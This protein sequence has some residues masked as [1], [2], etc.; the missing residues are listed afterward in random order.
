[1]TRVRFPPS[2]STVVL[3]A[4]ALGIAGCTVLAP[5]PDRTRFYLLAALAETPTTVRA[6]S[7]APVGLGPVRLPDYLGRL[8][9]AARTGHTEIRYASDDR[10]AEPLEQGM[11][12]VLAEN[13]TALLGGRTV[14]ALPNVLRR[15]V[16]F[17][18]PVEVLRFEPDA[19]GAVVLI[20]RW[21]VRDNAAAT[22]LAESHE[23]R[24]REPRIASDGDSG[25]SAMSRAALRLAEEIA[26]QIRVHE[27]L[28]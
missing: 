1:M 16:R 5:Q 19:E 21:S 20:A 23:S 10:W 11:T 26:A 18:V 7:A 13:L 4:A 8:D 25:A 28:R 17:E 9:M 22:P 27:G 12:R 2:S 6:A 15:D 14:V 3:W 24:L